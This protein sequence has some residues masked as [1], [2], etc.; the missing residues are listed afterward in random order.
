M[1]MTAIKTS[2]RD[3]ALIK[4]GSLKPVEALRAASAL[5]LFVRNHHRRTHSWCWK[6]LGIT[7]QLFYRFLGISRWSKKVKKLIEAQAAPLSQTVL[8]NLADQKWKDARQLFNKLQRIIVHLAQ[9]KRKTIEKLKNSRDKVGAYLNSMKENPL[10]KQS[11]IIY[12]AFGKICKVSTPNL[13][14]S[15]AHIETSLGFQYFIYPRLKC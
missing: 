7:K 4:A 2:D 9:R 8:F 6:K 12:M 11:K 14:R 1:K 3:T 15:M 5:R 13:D 10:K